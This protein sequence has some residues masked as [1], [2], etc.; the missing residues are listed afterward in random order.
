MTGQSVT[1]V[2]QLLDLEIVVGD[3]TSTG[4]FASDTE[5][6]VVTILGSGVGHDCQGCILDLGKTGV[7]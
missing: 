7:S 5:S 3:S 1:A 2:D 4:V 6:L